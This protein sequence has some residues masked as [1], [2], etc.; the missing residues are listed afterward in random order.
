MAVLF[1]KRAA[2]YV[3]LMVKADQ[4]G[5]FHAVQNYLLQKTI[6]F[7]QTDANALHPSATLIHFGHSYI[8]FA[9]GDRQ[10]QS[11]HSDRYKKWLLP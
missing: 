6:E 8:L 11:D 7:D 1:H 10:I 3:G 9:S 5:K 2:L 4:I